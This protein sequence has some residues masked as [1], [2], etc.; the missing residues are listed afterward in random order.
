MGGTQSS[1]CDKKNK[2][3]NKYT[4]GIE[5]GQMIMHSCFDENSYHLNTRVVC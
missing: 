2:L 3:L 5:Y 4:F 1:Q